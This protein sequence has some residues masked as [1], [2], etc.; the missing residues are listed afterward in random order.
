MFIKDKTKTQLAW[1]TWMIALANIM[2]FSIILFFVGGD[3]DDVITLNT[4]YI[5]IFFFSILI[6]ILSQLGLLLAPVAIGREWWIRSLVIFMMIPFCYLIVFQEVNSIIHYILPTDS[7]I[8]DWN[9]NLKNNLIS[10]FSVT[11]WIVI[12][13]YNLGALLFY[14]SKIFS[15]S[16]DK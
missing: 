6:A 10:V 9:N 5:G 14:K 3:S 13:L 16:S 8:V 11:T 2:I 1:I 15:F 12:Y 4:R 7:A